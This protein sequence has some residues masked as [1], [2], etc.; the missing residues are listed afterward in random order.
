MTEYRFE[1]ITE[2]N[3]LWVTLPPNH[4]LPDLTKIFK[5]GLH[6][7]GCWGT[8][9]TV[10]INCFQTKVQS[11]KHIRDDLMKSL[12]RPDDPLTC[13]TLVPQTL[14][15]AGIEFK[16]DALKLDIKIYSYTFPLTELRD[17]SQLLR[18]VRDDAKT[19]DNS[20]WNKYR[21]LSEH[22]YLN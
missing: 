21:F 11:P 8:V 19:H 15:N 17:F 5:Q 22:A 16:K 13:F 10:I 2:Y 9:K 6:N 3:E 1:Q 4:Y 12:E 18:K 14:T 7:D 20:R